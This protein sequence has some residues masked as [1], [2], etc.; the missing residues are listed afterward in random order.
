MP[1]VISSPSAR[2]HLLSTPETQ[3]YSNLHG[4]PEQRIPAS[5][6]A[7]L[8]ILIITVVSIVAIIATSTTTV[9]LCRASLSDCHALQPCACECKS[10]PVCGLGCCKTPFLTFLDVAFLKCRSRLCYI[11]MSIREVMKKRSREL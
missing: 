1:Y 8:L 10:G 11:C 7:S 6:V 3:H 2:N 4:R 5:M 9:F